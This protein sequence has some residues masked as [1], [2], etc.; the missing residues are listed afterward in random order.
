MEVFMNSYKHIFLFF[1]IAISLSVWAKKSP[2]DFDKMND[3]AKEILSCKVCA[4]NSQ[5]CVAQM[6]K[7]CQLAKDIYNNARAELGKDYLSVKELG[8]M[9]KQCEKAIVTIKSGTDQSMVK[10][11]M[12][13]ATQKDGGI[14]DALMLKAMDVS[15]ETKKNI[16]RSQTVEKK[17]Y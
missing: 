6:Q 10:K 2:I 13:E 8:M 1:L 14:A 12:N 4:D 3:Q 5:E 7:R 17:V 9:M 16:K 15:Q 11:I